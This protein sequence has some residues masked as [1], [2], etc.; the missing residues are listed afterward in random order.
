[1]E[2]KQVSDHIATLLPGMIADM[3]RALPVTAKSPSLNSEGKLEGEDW[4]K[5]RSILCKQ[6]EQSKEKASN[7]LA[8]PGWE[9]QRELL[10]QHIRQSRQKL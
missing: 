3:D 6:V 10:D 7:T 4:D 8:G 2:K 1:M 5:G 9:R